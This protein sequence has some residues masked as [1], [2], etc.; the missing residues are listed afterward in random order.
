MITS[1]SLNLE[2]LTPEAKLDL[3]WLEDGA[4]QYGYGCFET[5]TIRNGRPHLL[6]WHLERL[7]HTATF[8]K[9][10]IPFSDDAL[11]AHALD[12]CKGC[13]SGTLKWVLTAGRRQPNFTFSNPQF[14]MMLT[15][16]S[17]QPVSE[18]SVTLTRDP[19]PR[20][21]WD[22]YKTLNYAKAL[23]H[24]QTLKPDEDLIFMTQNGELLEATTSTLF[25]IKGNQLFT[26]NHPHIL[27]GVMRRWILEKAPLHG[28]SVQACSLTEQ[29]FENA[30]GAFLT[31]TLRLRWIKKKQ[32][33]PLIASQIEAIFNQTEQR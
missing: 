33:S 22:R 29:E 21:E 10:N 8:L 23:W 32:A 7:H 6:E 14:W 17:R 31:S 13:E 20:S 11:R 30:E 9:I 24:R 1:Y 4:F 27:Q 5:L 18:V 3:T 26:P 15:P 19:F 28:F 12:F 25:L 16:S 2:S